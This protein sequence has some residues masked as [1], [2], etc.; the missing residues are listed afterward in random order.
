MGRLLYICRSG[1][2][3]TLLSQI[4][5]HYLLFKKIL[6]PQVFQKINDFCWGVVLWFVLSVGCEMVLKQEQSRPRLCNGSCSD[7]C[8]YWYKNRHSFICFALSQNLPL[9]HLLTFAIGMY[10]FQLGDSFRCLNYF[11][12][13][14]W[15]AILFSQGPQSLQHENYPRTHAIQWSLSC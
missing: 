2:T 9:Q 12:S 11:E 3:K 8:S 14:S 15:Q 1:Q 13:E 5:S 10:F 6:K 4:S 7:V